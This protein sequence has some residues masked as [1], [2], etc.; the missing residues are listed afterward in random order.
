MKGFKLNMK[1]F[2]E[3]VYLFLSGLILKHRLWLIRRSEKRIEELKHK[4][5]V[6]NMYLNMLTKSTLQICDNIKNNANINQSEL[7]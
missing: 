3:T 4:L 1:I 2:K 6:E 5:K 7:R